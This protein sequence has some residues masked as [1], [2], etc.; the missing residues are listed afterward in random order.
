MFCGFISAHKFFLKHTITLFALSDRYILRRELLLIKYRPIIMVGIWCYKQSGVTELFIMRDPH[1]RV[2]RDL[3][4][5]KN[6]H[7]YIYIYIYIYTIKH[8]VYYRVNHVY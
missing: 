7:T 3:S 8:K 2:P 4:Y 5:T 1:Y 6:T